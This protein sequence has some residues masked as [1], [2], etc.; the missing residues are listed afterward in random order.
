[1]DYERY[2]TVRAS[3]EE[4]V[5]IIRE[6]KLHQWMHS[7]NIE[8]PIMGMLNNY[9]GQNWRIPEM[10]QMLAN[11]AARASLVRDTVQYAIEAHEVGIVVDFEEV[12]QQTEPHLQEFIAELGPAL[13]SVGLK[14][15]IA[16]SSQAMNLPPISLLL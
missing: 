14:M 2:I 13:R 10:V 5:S 3:P 4:A 9:D 15:T 16:A 1:M 11:P 6:D 8:I 7:A 12:P